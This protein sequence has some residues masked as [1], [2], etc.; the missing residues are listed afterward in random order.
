[1]DVVTALVE[2]GGLWWWI[3]ADNHRQFLTVL[4]S[5]SY[6]TRRLY[7]TSCYYPSSLF[8]SLALDSCL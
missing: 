5:R 4:D 8:L 6:V 7:K 2:N 1:V 3:I